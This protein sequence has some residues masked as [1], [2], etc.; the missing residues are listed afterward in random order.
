MDAIRRMA[1][2]E[3]AG[4]PVVPSVIPGF[5]DSH[6]FR[7]RG[8]GSYGFLPFVL[9]EDDERTVHGVNERISVENLRDGIRRLV[10]L[11]RALP[12]AAP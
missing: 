1:A 10:A 4:A 7:E 5:T 11:V 2:T 8:I 6:Y 9:S 12:A 3:L